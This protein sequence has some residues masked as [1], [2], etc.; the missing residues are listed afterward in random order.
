MIVYTSARTLSVKS[1]WRDLNPRPSAS[2]A[3][4]LPSCATLRW[5]SFTQHGEGGSNPY[6]A[7]LET[8]ALP[9]ELSPYRDCDA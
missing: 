5:L 6:K 8:A 3:D 7:A 4:A 1:E 2:E 9:L